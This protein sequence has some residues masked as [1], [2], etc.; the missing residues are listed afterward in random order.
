VSDDGPGIPADFLPHIFERFARADS[1]REH[2]R[3]ESGLGL[4]IVEAIVHAHDGSVTVTSGPGET[5]FTVRLPKTP[6]S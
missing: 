5:T 1:A 3:G 4:A 2:T 6:R